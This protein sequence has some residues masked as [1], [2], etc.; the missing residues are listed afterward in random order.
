[1]RGSARLLGVVVL[2]TGVM[3]A[4]VAAR[5]QTSPAAA[6]SG[7]SISV[8]LTFAPGSAVLRPKEK[9]ALNTLAI[10]LSDPSFNPYKFR[11]EGHTDTVGTPDSNKT[12]SQ[13]RAQA[14]VDYL[15]QQ[16]GIDRQ[17]LEPV[18]MGEDGLLVNTPDQTS[19]PRNRRVLVVTVGN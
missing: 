5:A 17:R 6:P 8:N 12:L 2:A 15:V 7:P 19:D 9:E 14:V 1:M 4:P 3:A 10:T 13:Q 16:C 18:G 11:I